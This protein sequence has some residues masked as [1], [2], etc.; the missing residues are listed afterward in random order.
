V[1]LAKSAEK[2]MENPIENSHG[3]AMQAQSTLFDE[4]VSWTQIGMMPRLITSAPKEI[5]QRKR[6]WD[7]FTT[8]CSR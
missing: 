5:R 8:L 1:I 3:V 2:I 6:G 7:A 4:S